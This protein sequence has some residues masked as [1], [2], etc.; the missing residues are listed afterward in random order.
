MSK[1]LNI[2]L[3][4][5]F[6]CGMTI[7]G[8][9]KFSRHHKTQFNEYNTSTI[10]KLIVDNSHG[11]VNYTGW[12]KD[13]LSIRISI[14]VEASY[15]GTANEILNQINIFNR[16]YEN[17]IDYNTHFS[18]NFFSNYN[19]GIDYHI[20]GPKNLELEVHNR[21]GNINLNDCCGKMKITGDYSNLKISESNKAISKANIK[22]INGNIDLAILASAEIIHKNGKLKLTKADNLL[23]NTDFS[24]A[25]IKNIG[26]LKLNANTSKLNIQQA[27]YVDLET[28]HSN[29]LISNLN[30]HGFIE[31]YEGSIDIKTLKNSLDTLTIAGDHCPINVKIKNELPFNLHGQVNNGKLFYPENKE[32]RILKEDNIV[33]FS[34]ENDSQNTSVANLIFFNKDS[35]IHLITIK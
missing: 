4:I 2:S 16:S 5:L 28:R 1:I 17:T 25:N 14:W 20:F 23:L 6:L 33:S 29:I 10:K 32:I 15:S 9:T 19:F 8:Q 35:D 3:L 7:S 30:Q 24:T 12:D 11:E 27:D 21:L 13:T 22:I 34:T 31:S 18:T 26:I